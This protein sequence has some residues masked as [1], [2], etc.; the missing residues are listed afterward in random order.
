MDG[1]ESVNEC[2][3][4]SLICHTGQN[5]GGPLSVT[6]TARLILVHLRLHWS[7]EYAIDSF[8]ASLGH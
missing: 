2:V 8:D 5:N 4:G 1:I 7:I 6:L 3:I